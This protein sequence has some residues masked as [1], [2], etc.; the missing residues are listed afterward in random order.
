MSERKVKLSIEFSKKDYEHV[1]FLLGKENDPEAESLWEKMTEKELELPLEFLAE[2][3]EVNK[4]GV[5]TTF[6]AMAIVYVSLE[7]H[8]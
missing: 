7:E 8:K 2:Q 3:M 6:L 4:A 1:L 5:V